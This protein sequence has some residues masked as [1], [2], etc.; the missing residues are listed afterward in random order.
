MA[1]R[2]HEGRVTA[3]QDA[4]YTQAEQRRDFALGS[5]ASGQRDR[6]ARSKHVRVPS[7]KVLET[8]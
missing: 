5:H 6:S 2:P 4:A 1:V 8:K 3:L 7:M